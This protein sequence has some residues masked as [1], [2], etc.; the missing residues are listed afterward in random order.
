MLTDVLT[1]KQRA[2]AELEK[3]LAQFHESGGTVRRQRGHRVA[4]VCHSGARGIRATVH[5]G[6]RLAAV[7]E[8][9]WAA[10]S[11]ALFGSASDY[12]SVT[13]T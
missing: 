13:L 3:L 12:L 5:K 11:H 9:R 8:A 6:F 1:K 10:V 4:I 2:R 7:T